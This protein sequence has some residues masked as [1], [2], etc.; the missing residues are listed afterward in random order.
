MAIL[1]N[2]LY[3]SILDFF[4]SVSSI[5]KISILLSEFNHFV[6]SLKSKSDIWL[7]LITFW[8]S[9]K[10]GILLDLDTNISDKKEF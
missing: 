3:F 1:Q 2:L 7:L 4:A 8:I 5:L 9:I 6:S 10:D